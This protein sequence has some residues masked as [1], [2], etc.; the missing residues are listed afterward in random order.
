MKEWKKKEL[1][2]AVR[3]EEDQDKF[4][5]GKLLH[6]LHFITICTLGM[7]YVN[8]ESQRQIVNT[9]PSQF[10]LGAMREFPQKRDYTPFPIN[11]GVGQDDGFKIPHN[12]PVQEAPDDLDFCEERG[13][14]S[15][16][17]DLDAPEDDNLF[18]GDFGEEAEEEHDQEME[19]AETAFES[20][21]QSHT[22]TESQAE[23]DR[24]ETQSY[25]TIVV[26]ARKQPQ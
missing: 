3:F 19:Q 2:D 17:D 12:V 23:V 1:Q 22:Q 13:E 10:G 21:N 4:M 9:M 25:S 24:A 5:K 11:L 16:W 18:G 20:G 26:S 14:F 6:H 7:R 8:A 15:L